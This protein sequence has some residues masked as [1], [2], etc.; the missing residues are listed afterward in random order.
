MKK[1]SFYLMIAVIAFAIS[2]NLSAQNANTTLSNLTAPVKINQSLLPDKTGKHN[3]G[4]G[5]K[6]WKNIYL[7]SAVYFSNSRFLSYAGT[8]SNT[9]VGFYTLSANSYGGYNTATGYAALYQNTA[10]QTNSATGTY[11]LYSNTEGSGNTANGYEA[12]YSN[13]TGN[14]NVAMGYTALSSNQTGY[15]NTANGASALSSNISGTRNTA[16]GYQALLENNESFNTAIGTYSLYQTTASQFNT[17]VGYAAGDSYN[18]GY[19]N[20]F[21][22]A[23]TDVNGTG[24]YNVIAMGQGTICTASSQAR[25]G[26]SAT[27]S[28][29]GYAN[30]SNISD[31]RVKKNIKQNVPGLAFINKLQ[32]VTYNL[33]LNAADK[34]IQYQKKDSTGKLIPLTQTEQTARSA[35]EKIIY[36]GF[37]AQ[38]VEKDAKSLNYDFSGVDAAKN[39]KDLY[40]L[41]YAEFVVPLVKA[42]QELSKMNDVKDSAIQQQNIKIDNLQQQLND[43]KKIIIAVNQS[44]AVANTST[45]TSVA[46]QQNTPNP[47]TNSTTIKYVLP[48]SYSSAKIIVTDK[49]RVALK[50]FN[51]YSNKGLVTLNASGLSAGAYQYTLYVDG[52]MIDSKQMIATK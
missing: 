9:A 23:N 8:T 25:F 16:I 43:L 37:I 17:A 21:V 28:I 45:I 13:S 14:Y 18:N 15:N 40:G 32:P 5:G 27:T 22:G 4:S 7:D 19:N 3:L 31:G 29:G 51:L 33:D 30:W 20:V 2:N 48:A 50:Q 12:L 6:A 46:L 47:F 49:N 11:S 39:N 42:V 38:D 26:N 44:P 10:G 36:T 34:I 52:R 24:Y 35:K 41:R 1:L